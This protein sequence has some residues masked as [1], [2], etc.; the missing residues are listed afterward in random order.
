MLIKSSQEQVLSGFK[1]QIKAKKQV[2]TASKE[3]NS[4]H[5]GSEA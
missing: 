4:L 5:N 3:E 1:R 2:N